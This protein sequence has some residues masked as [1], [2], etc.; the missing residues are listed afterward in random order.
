M[1]YCND[2]KQMKVE[3]DFSKNRLKHDGLSTYCKLCN[4]VRQKRY[5]R[6]PKFNEQYKRGIQLSKRLRRQALHARVAELKSVPCVDCKRT[7][8]PVAMDFDHLPGFEKEANVAVLVAEGASLE[9]VLREVEKCEVVCAC[10]HRIRTDR[11][12]KSL[13]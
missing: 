6:D 13:P 11:R 9:K 4:G 8:P 3:V 10:C 12:Q 5:Y 7:F 1:K 2:C